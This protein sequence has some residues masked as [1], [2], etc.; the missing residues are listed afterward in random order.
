MI[1]TKHKVLVLNKAWVPVSVI[2]LKK[3]I[4]LLHKYDKNDFP[5]AKILDVKDFSLFTWEDWSNLEAKTEDQV[6]RTVNRAFKVPEIVVLTT[7]CKHPNKRTV[8]NRQMLFKRDKYQCQY[9]G[10]KPGWAELNIDHIIPKSRGGKSCWTN[11]VISCVDCNTYK[12]NRTPE[13]AGMKLR[14]EPKKPKAN[15]IPTD[16]KCKSWEDVLGVCYW[17]IELED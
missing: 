1:L 4:R 11:C 8:F 9:C 17:S 12:K 6:I 10:I 15:F 14:K 16:Y 13:E 2:G 5:K 7:N 3:A